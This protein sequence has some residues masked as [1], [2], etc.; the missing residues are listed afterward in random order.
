MAAKLEVHRE[1]YKGFDKGKLEA[2]YWIVLIKLVDQSFGTIS[3]VHLL[4]VGME[5]I[6]QQ[7]GGIVC[8]HSSS[9]MKHLPIFLKNKK[10]NSQNHHN[11]R[12]YTEPQTL[13]LHNHHTEFR[14]EELCSIAQQ[15]DQVEWSMSYVLT[16]SISCPTKGCDDQL[17][18]INVL[19]VFFQLGFH[20]THCK[21]QS[22]CNK[23]NDTSFQKLDSDHKS[24]TETHHVMYQTPLILYFY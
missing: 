14:D 16:G 21:D 7:K 23:Y 8:V 19:R 9:K 4:V 5:H 18:E 17:A 20:G 24:H 3:L 6:F 12:T 13:F 15:C 1:N 2:R 10:H 22:L 11:L